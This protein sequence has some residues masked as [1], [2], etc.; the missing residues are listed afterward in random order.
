[1]PD[2]A[3]PCAPP[4]CCA[5]RLKLARSAETSWTVAA[6]G[7]PVARQ[8]RRHLR[9]GRVES[10][11][12]R[13]PRRTD[14]PGSWTGLRCVS[15]RGP[16]DRPPFRRG[17]RA[18][19]RRTA[20]R[21]V[22]R[23]CRRRSAMVHCELER[24]HFR[25]G[26]RPRRASSRRIA[27]GPRSAA[28]ALPPRSGRAS[29][30]C[31]PPLHLPLRTRCVADTD[32]QDQALRALTRDGAVRWECRDCGR[33][34]VIFLLAHRGDGQPAFADPTEGVYNRPIWSRR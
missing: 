1:M 16:S 7:T 8:S 14:L 2:T 30:A 12:R 29:R 26:T 34:W 19:R 6:S 21:R 10:H 28:D 24:A 13:R 18:P 31:G 17:L 11:R 33:P 15:T 32:E 4:S 3:R 9:R 25:R 5:S 20:F 27:L 23:T 22:A